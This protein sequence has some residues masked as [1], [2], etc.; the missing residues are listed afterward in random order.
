MAALRAGWRWRRDGWPLALQLLTRVPHAGE[1]AVMSVEVENP[2][3]AF[4]LEAQA[5]PPA[6]RAATSGM[7]AAQDAPAA[8][9]RRA[10]NVHDISAMSDGRFFNHVSKEAAETRRR[11]NELKRAVEDAALTH[12]ADMRRINRMVLFA[13]YALV[14]I[15]LAQIAV[16][17][18]TR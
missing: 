5:L 8:T 2:L 4:L 14:A 6:R 16:A 10:P 18:W 3:D 11:L 9:G 13:V 17:I 15:G 7:S 12:A 1:Q